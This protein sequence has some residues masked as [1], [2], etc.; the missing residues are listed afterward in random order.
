MKKRLFL[1]MVL[2]TSIILSTYAV[3]LPDD[4]GLIYK[5]YYT[6]TGT[7]YSYNTGLYSNTGLT[8][9][10]QVEIYRDHLIIDGAN[11]QYWHTDGNWLWYGRNT[12]G[13][14]HPVYLYNISSGELR[15]RYNFEFFGL[16]VN[17]MFLYR[18]NLTMYNSGTGTVPSTG[19]SYSGSSGTTGRTP[20]RCGLCDGKG[21]VPTEEGVPTYGS[22]SQKYCNDCRRYVPINHWH[23]TCPSCKGKGAW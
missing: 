12:V 10:H 4:S 16:Q 6:N 23:K 5:G 11:Y 13:T 9:L 7:S 14:N 20:H 18:G 2:L 19:G 15:W 3:K 21:W 1:M 8:S 17:D 22:N